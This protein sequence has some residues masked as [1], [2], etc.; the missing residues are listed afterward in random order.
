MIIQLFKN[1][2]IIFWVIDMAFTPR[3]T[4]NGIYNSPYWYSNGN[5]FYP[6]GYGLPNC[7]CYAYG[8]YWEI[9]GVNPTRLPRGNAGT[10]YDNATS[11]Q[12]GQTPALGAIA[13][14]YDPAGYYA[15]HVAVVEQIYSN[16]N[17]RTSNSGYYRPI[18]SYP[19]DT[20]SYF[21][22]EDCIKDSG[23]RSSWEINRGYR[24][25]GFIY[26]DG[27]PVPSPDVPQNWIYGQRYLSASEMENNAY[28]VYSYLYTRGWSYNAICALLG[29]MV[30]ESTINPAIYERA[31]DPSSGYGLV[32]WTPS[33]NYINWANARGYDITNGN[34]QL[35]WI[36][37]E[38]IPA[39]QWIPTSSFPM[40]WN[41]FIHSTDNIDYLTEVFM[42]EFERPYL[43]TADLPTRKQWANYF[44]DYLYNLDPLNPPFNPDER[45]KTGLKVWQMI[46][47]RY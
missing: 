39:G 18:S 9:T 2:L 38:T 29:N 26:L 5:P 32:Q 1:W 37:E 10:W 33:T 44:Y 43:P 35:Q 41:D 4:A 45:R 7:T 23:Y 30:K 14:W 20:P 46:R 21:W 31:G 19:P 25:K 12:R 24:L 27:E 3:L 34:Y 15:G 42:M 17:I 36:D 40:S 11:F 6:S 13:C 16:G 28:L 47:Y 8:R 22:T